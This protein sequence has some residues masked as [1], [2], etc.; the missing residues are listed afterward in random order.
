MI[1]EVSTLCV[2][3][4]STLRR[5]QLHHDALVHDPRRRLVIVSAASK[6]RI[7][8]GRNLRAVGHPAVVRVMAV[9]VVIDEH[10]VIDPSRVD[11]D[12][13]IHDGRRRRLVDVANIVNTNVVDVVVVVRDVG[14]VSDARVADIHRLEVVPANAVVRDVRLAVTQREP[15]HTNAAATNPGDERRRVAGTPASRTGHPAPASGDEYP[16]TI[17]ERS[18]APGGI[19]D[20]GPT[21]GFDPCPV[22]IAIR[23]PSYFDTGW[24]PPA[25]VGP[26][27]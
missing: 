13:V 24:K 6:H 14:D 17:M 9:A 22:S 10:I 23:R 5:R 20:P 26:G 21:P 11:D 25:A 1:V 19:V 15:A 18:E 4:N 7:M 16:P 12:V 3:G 2:E 27:L 8:R